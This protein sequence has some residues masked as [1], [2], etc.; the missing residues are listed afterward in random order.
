MVKILLIF[1]GTEI[2]FGYLT[3]CFI[4]KGQG[5]FCTFSIINEF[6]ASVFPFRYFVTINVG[7]YACVRE[8]PRCGHHGFRASICILPV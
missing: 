4:F 5:F 6:H 1:N 8:K 7:Y 2:F 3:Q